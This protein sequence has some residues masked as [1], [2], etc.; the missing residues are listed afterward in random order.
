MLVL[1][2][3]VAFFLN[4]IGQFAFH[5]A[6]WNKS[7]GRENRPMHCSKNSPIGLQNAKV[8]DI[9]GGT[10]VDMFQVAMALPSLPGKHVFKDRQ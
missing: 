1:A 2:L 4:F 7:Q 9:T 10:K 5:Q 6:P 8:P 3:D